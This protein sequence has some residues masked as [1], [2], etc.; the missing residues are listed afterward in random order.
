MSI[1]SYI[2]SKPELKQ[3]TD[4][5][6]K[7][8]MYVWLFC[9]LTKRYV[10][11]SMGWLG[12]FF[13]I[14]Y[15][16][17]SGFTAEC[18]RLAKH[19]WGLLRNNQRI[20]FYEKMLK[21]GAKEMDE[22]RDNYDKLRKEYVELDKA[23]MAVDDVLKHI[24][25][26]HKEERKKEVDKVTEEANKVMVHMRNK[27]GDLE[28]QLENHKQRRFQNNYNRNRGKRNYYHHNQRPP[29]QQ[30]QKQEERPYQQHDNKQHQMELQE[31]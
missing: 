19:H 15:I 13:L 25:A 28:R 23:K 8:F 29:Y 14:S 16:Y 3:M 5:I 31:W 6:L 22:L 4:F 27:I 18:V 10:K 7:V 9:M 12:E 21:M 24:N 17:I 20:L 26:K 1:K 2:E 30:S 11:I